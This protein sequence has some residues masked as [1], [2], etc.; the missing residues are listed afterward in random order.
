ME[1]VAKTHRLSKVASEFNISSST[2]IEFLSKKGHKMDSN[3]NQKLSSDMYDLLCKEFQSEKQVKETSKKLDI[4]IISR[5]ETATPEKTKEREKE[6]ERESE[7]ELIIKNVAADFHKE[8][9]KPVE[10]TVEKPK[11]EKPKTDKTEIDKPAAETSKKT[12]VKDDESEKVSKKEKT[13]KSDEPE[14]PEITGPVVLGKIDL[15]KVNDKKPTK[16]TAEEKKKSKKSKDESKSA[17]PAEEAITEPVDTEITSSDKSISVTE[18]ES[19]PAIHETSESEVIESE[20]P[21]VEIEKPDENFL[22]TNYT[23]LEG[24]KILGS[25]VLPTVKEPQKKQPVAS[26]SENSPYNKKKKRKRLKPDAP[27]AAPT[28]SKV[29]TH[30][31]PH[32]KSKSGVRK[33]TE[34]AQQRQEPTG[35]EIQKQIRETLARLSAPT[36]SKASKY[37]RQKR[38]AIHQQ[39]E[40]E[41]LQMEQDKKTL[42]VTEFVTVSELS[43]LMGV[44]VNDIISTCMSLGLFVSIN[45]RLDAEVLTIVAEEFGYKTQ[46]VSSEIQENLADAA[47]DPKLLVERPPIV[48]VMGHVDHGKTSLLDYIRNANVI[49]GEAGGITQHIGA[50]EVTLANGKEITFLDTPG[51]EAFTAMRAR[52]A[53]VTNMAI[54]VI[55]ADDSVMPQ[56]IEAINHAQAAKVPLIFAIN[57]IDKTGANP[58][59]IKEALANMNL[60]VEDWGGSYQCQE[61]SAKQGLNIDKLLEKVLL[62]S[63]MLELKANPKRNALG[64]ILESSLEKGRGYVAKL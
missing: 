56:T 43:K 53:K 41:Q 40:E 28:D 50:Y 63:E 26:S 5:L 47:D 1:E 48:T 27:L 37:R 29:G 15:D 54:I 13:K 51:H 12:K 7:K 46:F 2:I 55:A 32:T 44:S 42:Q 10:K 58:E 20:I 22:A 39:L 36:K 59:K 14:T 11:T 25:I 23:K 6:E 61:I 49:A 24:P 38:D 16:K 21:P 31:S 34:K 17:L 18:Q 62:E 45:Q 52:G 9:E 33:T 35:E 8:T 60:L 19:E 57:K 3:P 64:T 4:G 30:D